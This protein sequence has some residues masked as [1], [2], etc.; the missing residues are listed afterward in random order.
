MS[1]RLHYL[2]LAGVLLLAGICV[3]QWRINRELN[4][5]TNVLEKERIDQGLRIEE[6]A[7]QIKGQAADLDTFREHVQRLAADLKS[8]ESNLSASRVEAAQLTAQNDQLK[9]SLESWRKAVEERDEQLARASEQ[10]QQLGT[11]RNE[12]VQKFNNLAQK[13]NEVVDDLNARTREFNSLV[14]RY[15]AMA[16][17]S[18]S[19]P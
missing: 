8:A 1:R 5:R 13:H 12:V 19:A 10:L 14:E 18:R 9:E 7:K 6:Q 17:S 16:K 2:N 15:N 3:L 4:L 11:E